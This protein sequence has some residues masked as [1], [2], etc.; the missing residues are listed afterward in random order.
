VRG[1]VEDDPFDPAHE[2]KPAGLAEKS[3]LADQYISHATDAWS[4]R[5]FDEARAQF[6]QAY[7]TD[8]KS[9]ELCR[10]KW[11]Y[12]IM[13]GVVDRLNSPN[14]G[15]QS[16]AD[17]QQQVHGALA[18]APSLDKTGQWLLKTIEQRYQGQTTAAAIAGKDEPIFNVQH[19]GKNPQGYFVTETPRFRI[20]HNQ[21]RE[22]V[23]KVAQATERTTAAMA[24]KWL[25]KDNVDWQGK[26]EVVLY[27]TVGD[28]SKATG[29]STSSPGHA[30]IESDTTTGRVLNRSLHLRCDHPEMLT[31]TLP[32]ETTHVVLAGSFD[33]HAPPRWADEGIASL[34]EPTEKIEKYRRAVQRMAAEGQLFSLSDLFNLQNYPER[35]KIDAFYAQSVTVVEYLAQLRGPTTLPEF[36]RDALR[37]SYE[38]ALQKHYSLSLNELQMRWQQRVLG[39]GGVAARNENEQ[40]KR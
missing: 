20:Y 15:G 35:R 11:A 1:K 3:R 14:L 27:G 23:D 12:C 22:L 34:S 25:G 13:S 18:L 2:R 9:I 10:D 30:H 28:Y 40:V 37:T 33:Q 31:V 38:S 19:Y 39:E 17:L 8:A 36:V 5:R 7:N 4:K 21:P 26:C 16:L 29:V 6:E 32:H 24:R